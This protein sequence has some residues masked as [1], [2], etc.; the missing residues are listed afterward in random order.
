MLQMFPFEVDLFD[1]LSGL[2]S[3][4]DI[5]GYISLFNTNS[6]I[7]TQLHSAPL[8]KHVHRSDYFSLCQTHQQTLS[9]ILDYFLHFLFFIYTYTKPSKQAMRHVKASLQ[10]VDQHVLKLPLIVSDLQL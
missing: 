4:S 1:S 6:L 7:K 2:L 8:I 5:L 9:Y 3:R 10:C